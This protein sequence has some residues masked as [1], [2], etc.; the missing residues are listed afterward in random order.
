MMAN[1]DYWQSVHYICNYPTGKSSLVKT[2]DNA[3]ALRTLQH[4]D[5][6]G[7][8]TAIHI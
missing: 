1:R 8:Y 5:L 2:K 7:T 6:Y 3:T 4:L